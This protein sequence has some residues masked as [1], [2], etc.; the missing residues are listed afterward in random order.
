MRRI[1][2]LLVMILLLS[3]SALPTG[4]IDLKVGPQSSAL[5]YPSD[6]LLYISFRTDE[7]F[8]EELQTLI[9]GVNARLPEEMQIPG[10]GE[11]LRE[12]FAGD[13]D[14]ETVM[15]WLGDY[16]AIGFTSFDASDM[17][18]YGYV[19]LDLEDQ[20]AAEAFMDG[21]SDRF[22]KGT[23]GDFTIYTD[24]NDNRTVWGFG[25]GVLVISDA[26]NF[27]MPSF[28]LSNSL[29]DS[30]GF[31]NS[32]GQL[33]VESYNGIVY[34]DFP[35]IR[36][37]SDLTFGQPEIVIMNLLG[38]FAAGF[39][40]LDNDTLTIDVVQTGMTP[41]TTI[42]ESFAGYI[43]A[44]T[45][46][47]IHTS[48][49]SGLITTIA[50]MTDQT[51][52]NPLAQAEEMLQQLGINLQQ[53]VLSWTTGDYALLLRSDLSGFL[54]AMNE[55]GNDTDAMEFFDYGLVVAATDPVKAQVFAGKLSTLVNAMASAEASLTVSSETIN[56]IVVTVVSAPANFGMGVAE[57]TIEILIGAN[58]DIFF[59]GSRRMIEGVLDGDGSVTS[60]N[61]YQA[62]SVHFL[63]PTASMWYADGE[64]LSSV[65]VIPITVFIMN[66]LPVMSEAPMINVSYSQQEEASDFESMMAIIDLM[67][68]GSITSTAGNNA[69]IT[70][71]ALSLNLDE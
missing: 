46:A 21:R 56:D 10:L 48:D 68:G 23:Q 13:V 4:A 45:S 8:I 60:K 66:S 53:D 63:A 67:N 17:G 41:A 30:E 14:F 1:A 64:G 59:I 43:P 16:G 58:D 9:Q 34:V 55:E 44:N 31:I 26:E 15:G 25:D 20:A 70:R 40:I 24:T 11:S 37:Q 39:V 47:F 71:F 49:L 42:S 62:A 69:T 36:E 18:G 27:T 12:G 54:G 33:P 5:Y 61:N 22:E 7:D 35:A 2:L 65:V 50:N 32:V 6:T 52:G 19:T 51:G 29:R 38:E 28:P 3:F 57:S